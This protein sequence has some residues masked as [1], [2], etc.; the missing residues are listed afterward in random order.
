MGL[1][2]GKV[3]SIFLIIAVGFG[4]NKIGI[5]PT[6]SK[7]Y[8]V[9]L[10]ILITTPCVVFTSIAS[11]ELTE[12]TVA[13]TLETIG[14][15]I[16][17][18][19]FCVISGYFLFKKIIKVKPEEDLSSYIFA[20]GSFNSGFMGFPITLALFGKDILYL[21]VMLN[22]MLCL[23]MYTFGPMILK[24]G[25]GEKKRTDVR[26]LLSSL[27]NPNTVMTLLGLF[28]LFTGL[29]LPSVI[30]DC[31]D[32][33]GDATVPLSLLIVGMQLGESDL[34]GILKNKS[35]VISSLLK[36]CLLPAVVFLLVNWLPIADSIKLTVVFSAAFPA[37]VAIVPVATIENRDA[38]VLAESV[39][40]T[41]AMS[42]ASIPI[43]AVLLTG[44]FG[45]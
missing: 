30:F 19:I 4:A 45:L 43:C 3:V 44:Y 35:L 34:K 18:H 28:M 23:Y 37:A 1:I 41:T 9:D 29:H 22:S 25:S 6:E 12:D 26:M 27:K 32:T 2:V 21:M 42:I 36:V 24:I 15:A 38:G 5:L 14:I 17:L 33:L 11:K 13:M 7:K 31:M 16:C 40:L 8:V 20:F 10:L 39:A